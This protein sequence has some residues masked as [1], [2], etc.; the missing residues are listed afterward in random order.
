MSFVT[1]WNPF[2]EPE[3]THATFGNPVQKFRNP[4]WFEQLQKEVL[5]TQRI[6]N[7]FP[8]TLKAEEMG[9]TYHNTTS[10]DVTALC[11]ERDGA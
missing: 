7:G 1:R 10:S 4:I 5:N 11:R 3:K 9:V 2:K 6:A 8:K